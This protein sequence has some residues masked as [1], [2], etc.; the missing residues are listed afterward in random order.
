[1]KVSE[2]PCRENGSRA[3]TSPPGRCANAL[4]ELGAFHTHPRSGEHRSGTID[5]NNTGAVPRQ[6][7]RNTA[8][9][10]T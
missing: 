5:A 6:W 9:A 10:A 2:T 3:W 8:R 4:V 7:K 1:M